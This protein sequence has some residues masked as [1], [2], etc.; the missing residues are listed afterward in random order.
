[1]FTLSAD[2]RALIQESTGLSSQDQSRK[3]VDVCK[4]WDKSRRKKYACPTQRTIKARGSVYVQAG[5]LIRMKDVRHY[6]AKFER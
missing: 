3:S 4:Q 5:R 2:T 1:M 6:L